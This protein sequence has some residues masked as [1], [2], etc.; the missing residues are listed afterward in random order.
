MSP[1]TKTRAGRR[2]L[3]GLAISALFLAPAAPAAVPNRL[4]YQGKL[5][6]DKGVAVAD[7]PYVML[8]SLYGQLAGGPSLWSETQ[9]VTVRDGIFSVELGSVTP[10]PAT[11]DFLSQYYLETKVGTDPPLPRHQ[12]V[13]AAHALVA[14][15]AGAGSVGSASIVD[16]SVNATHIASNS[17]SGA[18]VRDGSLRPD[19]RTAT[20]SR[21]ACAPVTNPVPVNPVSVCTAFP[22][23][24]QATQA[25]V[26]VR[27]DQAVG[28]SAVSGKSARLETRVE[29]LYGG[30]T[31]AEGTVGASV[32]LQG[33][34]ANDSLTMMQTLR[35][36]PG[37]SALSA[38]AAWTN[39]SGSCTSGATVRWQNISVSVAYLG[40]AQ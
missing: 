2:R 15:R 39:V 1:T 29:L 38:R 23:V 36:E 28:C 30:V 10:F 13:G 14:S 26:V 7:G 6:D 16:G 19:D 22:S 25:L 33:V 3:A 8:F 31:V 40:L 35:I 37:G 5:A 9:S 24:S 18:K 34:T 4:S 32:G 12:L 21:L 17:V 11:L 20:V 27:L